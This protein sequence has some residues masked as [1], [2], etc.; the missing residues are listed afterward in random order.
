MK[1][2]EPP[3]LSKVPRELKLNEAEPINKNNNN[4]VLPLGTTEGRGAFNTGTLPNPLF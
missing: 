4:M 1:N 3:Q 2:V